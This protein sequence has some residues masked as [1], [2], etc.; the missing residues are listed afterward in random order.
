LADAFGSAR[1]A[2]SAVPWLVAAVARMA[3]AEVMGNAPADG[4]ELD[5]AADAVAVGHCLDLLERQ[6]G[7]ISNSEF[8]AWRRFLVDD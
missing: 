6:R 2:G 3:A 4:V 1:L 7:R 5:P 8:V